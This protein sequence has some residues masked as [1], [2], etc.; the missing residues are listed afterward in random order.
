[1]ANKKIKSKRSLNPV[2]K[3]FIIPLLLIP[4]CFA[5]AFFGNT[6]IAHDTLTV[7]TYEKSSSDTISPVEKSLFQGEKISGNFTS[8]LNNLGIMSVRF[9]TYNRAG[10]DVLT[11]RIKEHGQKDWSYQADYKVDQF[12]NKQL[13]TF[14]FPLITDAK[15]KVYD[16]EIESTKGKKN[17][18]VSVSSIEPIFVTKYKYS[19]KYALT[20][21]TDTVSFLQKKAV[22][23]SPHLKDFLH[24]LVYLSPIFLY[25]F[26]VLLKGKMSKILFSFVFLLLIVFIVTS[27]EFNSLFLQDFQIIAAFWLI[28]AIV[29]R[30]KSEVTFILAGI[31]LAISF[32]ISLVGFLYLSQKIAIFVYWIFAAGLVELLIEVLLNKKFKNGYKEVLRLISFRD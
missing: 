16:F 30:V 10:N 3:W 4:L 19:P 23:L 14:G 18:A 2:L 9:N 26:F 31:I 25:L 5:V 1:M 12:Q 32:L 29:F 13:F 24:N 15:N 27:S 21:I 7:M 28:G 11:F 8:I 6:K 22:I 17:D 20:H